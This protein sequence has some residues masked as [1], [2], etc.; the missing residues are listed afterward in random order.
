RVPDLTAILALY[1]LLAVGALRALADRG[2][3]VPDDVA[4]IG[5]NDEVF[6]D[7]SVPRLSTVRADCNHMGEIAA[8]L[9]LELLGDD[10]AEAREVIVPTKLIARDSTLGRMSPLVMG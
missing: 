9:M 4:V 1:D 8:K 3:R 7:Y 6:A 5:Y 2:K 10:G